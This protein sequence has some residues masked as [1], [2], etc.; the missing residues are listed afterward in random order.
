MRVVSG[1]LAFQLL[2]LSLMHAA[3]F[4][5]LPPPSLFAALMIFLS[6]PERFF[7]HFKINFVPL[8]TSE[9]AA[10]P[11]HRLGFKVRPLRSWKWCRELSEV[12]RRH[13]NLAP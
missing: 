1:D 3:R 2:N 6:S 5:D 9:H 4:S 10:E 12:K 7:R 8:L 11:P 13:S